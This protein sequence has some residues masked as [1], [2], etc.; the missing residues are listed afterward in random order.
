VAGLRL[1]DSLAVEQKRRARDEVRLA[2]EV[3][4]SPRELND[5]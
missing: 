5:Y 3:L 1:A 2:D 4:P